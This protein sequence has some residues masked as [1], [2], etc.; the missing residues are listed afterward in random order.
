MGALMRAY[1][2]SATPLGD[3]ETWCPTLQVMTSWLDRYIHREDQP[4]VTA[5]IA[6]SID[7]RSK[8]EMEH[9]VRRADGSIG[10]TFSRA[11]PMF[12]VNGEIVEWFGTATDVTARKVAEEA[13]LRSEK[14]A[15]LGRMAATTAHEINNPLEALG[16]LLFLAAKTENVP[17]E[18]V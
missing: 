9:R 18:A 15:S 12:D 1:D 8:F 2:W 14:L 10:W 3:P 16:N 5:A 6:K 4:A 11:V 13:L 17:R 7:A